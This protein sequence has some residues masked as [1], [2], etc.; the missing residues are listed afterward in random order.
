LY[1]QLFYSTSSRA[2]RIAFCPW[3]LHE[4]HLFFPTQSHQ[5]I[6]PFFW[7]E[8]SPPGWLFSA[9]G[10]P[11]LLAPPE[12][13][14]GTALPLVISAQVP[15]TAGRT[16]VDVLAAHECPAITARRAQRQVRTH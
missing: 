12:E 10:I 7:V 11:A 1:P 8:Y 13:A 14:A 3:Y 15:G 4:K 2:Y 16:W 9:L 5:G 6:A